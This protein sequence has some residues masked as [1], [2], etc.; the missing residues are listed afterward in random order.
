[1]SLRVITGLRKG[2]RIKGPENSLS[3]PTE[4]RIKENV[5]N[6]I[7]PFEEGEIALDLFACTGNIGIEFLSRGISKVYFSEI[8]KTNLALLEENLKHTKFEENAKV[9][10]GDFRFNIAQIKE[11]I[12]YVYI[13]PPYDTNYY[14]EALQLMIGNPY[15]KNA[16]YITEKNADSDLSEIFGT[17]ELVYEKKYGKKYIKF[18]REKE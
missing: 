17:I 2:F 8:N 7:T 9:L 18:Y 3:R 4:D 1:M 10:K 16:L 13:D 6:I 11:N 12:D 5:F 14:E 15:F